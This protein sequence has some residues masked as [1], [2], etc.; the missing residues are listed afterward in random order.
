MSLTEILFKISIVGDPRVGK[1]TLRRTYLGESF[2]RNYLPTVGA[3]FSVYKLQTEAMGKMWNVK[4][5][6]WDLAGQE[7][8]KPV[9]SRY[10]NGTNILLVVFDVTNSQSF[11]NVWVWLE[12]SFK[13]INASEVA[14]TI[15]ANKID[16]EGDRTVDGVTGIGIVDEINQRFEPLN[17]NYVETSALMGDNVAAAFETVVSTLIAKLR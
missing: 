2:P 10:L 12:E 1:T 5:S 17:T 6:I 8:F 3:D 16:L 9:I 7:L 14:V 4:L 15:V 11:D 13:I